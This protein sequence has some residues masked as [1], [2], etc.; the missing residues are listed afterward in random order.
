LRA[1]QVAAVTRSL[2]SLLTLALILVALAGCSDAPLATPAESDALERATVELAAQAGRPIADRYIVVFRGDVGDPHALTDAL[3]RGTGGTLHFRYGTALRGFAA[4]LPAAAIEGIRRNP[5]VAYVE[6]DAV[7]TILQTTQ[8]NATW[9]LD[10]VDQPNRPLDGTYTYD[11][12][13]AGVRAYIID[14]GILSS[15]ADFGG[16]AF[17]GFSAFSGGS[18]DC[19]GHGTHVAGTV[20][21]ATWGVAKGVALVA[22][23]VLDCNGSGTTSGVI[24]GVDWVTANHQ[25]PAVANMSLGGGASSSLDTAVGNSIAAGVTYAVAA[26]NG[27]RLGRQQNACNY[28]PARV[29]AAITIGAT[30]SSDA[31][32]S[33]SNYGGC[34]DWFAPGASITS[35]WHTGTTATNTISGTSMATPHVAGAAALYL[36]ANP[37]ATPEQVR[38]AL[39]AL[40]TKGIVTSSS[41]TNNHLLYTRL[42]TGGGGGTVNQPPVAAFTHTCT[43]LTCTFD[44]STSSDPDGTITAYAWNFGDGT[45]GSGK[46]TSRTYT[47]PATY[48]ITLAV[49]DDGGTT[50]STSQSVTVSAPSTGGIALAAVGYKVQGLQRVDL[51]WSGATTTSVVVYRGTSALATVANSGSYT[52]AINAR[53]GGSYTYRVCEAGSTTACSNTVTVT[54]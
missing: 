53:G 5:N 40:T 3:L 20:G 22:V 46:T 12:A 34:V 35:A 52:D 6:Q 36:A 2:R 18:E 43:G 13:G 38:D 14:T 24:A 37:L 41:T 39:Y 16:R 30:T 51:S 47:G 10:R 45:T 33:W 42:G 4:T 48:T 44:A 7:M 21:G 15:H 31:K 17:P 8:G 11:N 26:G 27:D 1:E 23:R 19:N 32:T 54:F 29:P 49:T 9:G 25:K 50:V 28:S